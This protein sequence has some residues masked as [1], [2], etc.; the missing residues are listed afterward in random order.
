V[1]RRSRLLQERISERVVV[2]LKTGEAFG[3]VLWDADDRLWILRNTT[4][5]GAG[6]DGAA[7]PLDGEV[8][9]LTADILHAQRP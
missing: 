7:L 6:K 8:I 9:V 3:G 2:T 1:R 4:A 5:L